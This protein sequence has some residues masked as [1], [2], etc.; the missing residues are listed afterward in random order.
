M[1]QHH[2]PHQF[3]GVPAKALQ[4]ARQQKPGIDCYFQWKRILN[5]NE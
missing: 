1:R 4:L 2:A 5:L 3:V